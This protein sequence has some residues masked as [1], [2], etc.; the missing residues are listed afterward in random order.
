MVPKR[1]M[2]TRANLEIPNSPPVDILKSIGES[3]IAPDI[4]YL[5]Q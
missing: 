1:R 3:V 4:V 2:A 5:A